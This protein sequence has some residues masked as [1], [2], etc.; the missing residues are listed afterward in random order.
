MFTNSI[1]NNT[2][3]AVMQ[4]CE[5]GTIPVPFNEVLKFCTAI[6]IE[7]YGFRASG[8]GAY[9][10]TPFWK[11]RETVPGQ[12]WPRTRKKASRMIVDITHSGESS[13]QAVESHSLPE[14]EVCNSVRD[15]H[16]L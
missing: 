1:I 12:V 3:V 7:K 14:A 13:A 6:D 9:L 5:V 11:V 10:P 16:M 2:N 4:T 8:V 15:S